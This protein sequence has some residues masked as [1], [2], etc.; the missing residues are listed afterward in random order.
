MQK[1]LKFIIKQKNQLYHSFLSWD[2]AKI[3]HTSFENFRHAWPH[4]SNMVVSTCR[5]L[6][7]LSALKFN[8]ISHF[9]LKILWRF[10]KLAILGTLQ[11]IGLVQRN[12]WHQ[13]LEKFGVY[14]HAKNQLHPSFLPWDLQ[15]FIKL[16]FWVSWEC[17]GVTT[18]NDDIS[19]QKT[20][21]FISLL[22]IKFIPHLFLE[23][24]QR[25]C[26]LGILGFLGM[27]SHTHQK[28]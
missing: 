16:L 8:F 7:C 2:N 25:Y 21:M 9:F 20:L 22:K 15:T 12:C 27:H 3:L 13:L 28:Q 11:M 10:C 14:L 18:K 6:W 4:A 19:L 24:L 1:T 23:I 26:K 5:K 17:L